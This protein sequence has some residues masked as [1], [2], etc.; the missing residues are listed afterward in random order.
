MQ[1][2]TSADAFVGSRNNAQRMREKIMEWSR[3]SGQYGLTD[4]ELQ[5]KLESDSQSVT[6]ARLS[7]ERDGM[8]FWSGRIRKTRDRCAA[9]VWVLPEYDH[10]P[11]RPEIDASK[12]YCPACGRGRRTSTKD[13]QVE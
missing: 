7:L 2:E 3:L 11:R 12:E 8:I 9:M 13:V 10:M 6:P 4:D 5:Q 1:P